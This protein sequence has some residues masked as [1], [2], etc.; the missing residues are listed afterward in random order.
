[1]RLSTLES[2]NYLYEGLNKSELKS[3]KLWESAGYAISEAQLTADQIQQLFQDVEK[4]ST[5]A[6]SNRTAI[7]QGKDVAVAVKKAY[8]DL[9]M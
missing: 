6:G 5:D 8:D 9:V 7:G 3:I 1:M 4:N 2:K